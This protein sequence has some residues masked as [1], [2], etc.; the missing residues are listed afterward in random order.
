MMSASSLQQY[1]DWNTQYGSELAWCPL[2]A[3]N[4][5]RTETHSMAASSHEA[6][7]PLILWDHENRYPCSLYELLP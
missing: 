5:T 4:S 1:E 6:A 3:C 2:P 7:P